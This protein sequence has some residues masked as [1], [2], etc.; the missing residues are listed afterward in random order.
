MFKV[1]QQVILNKK[2]IL[3]NYNKDNDYLIWCKKNLNKIFKIKSNYF[4][5]NTYNLEGIETFFFHEK[6]LLPITS[7]KIKKLIEEI[8]A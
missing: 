8:N 1:G 4:F 6:E 3:G 7:L 5:E 2:E